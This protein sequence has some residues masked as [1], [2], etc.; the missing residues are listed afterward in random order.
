MHEVIKIW[1]EIQ[2]MRD[3]FADKWRNYKSL[4]ETDGKINQKTIELKQAQDKQCGIIQDMI[5]KDFG[6]DE[7]ERII[8]GAKNG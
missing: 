1:Q 5:K 3:D 4:S 6:S 7:L 2:K 8:K